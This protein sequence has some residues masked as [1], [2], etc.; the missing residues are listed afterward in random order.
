MLRSLLAGLAMSALTA[1]LYALWCLFVPRQWGLGADGWDVLLLVGVM[2]SAMGF[3]AGFIC[4][5]LDC[6]AQEDTAAIDERN[7][8]L[9]E[10][11]REKAS[12][13]NAYALASVDC[14]TAA[15]SG[16]GASGRFHLFSMRWE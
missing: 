8:R 10:M 6:R 15:D 2:L 14:A 7:R 5:R 4:S 12:R 9:D 13:L 11:A 3:F 16:R 1:A